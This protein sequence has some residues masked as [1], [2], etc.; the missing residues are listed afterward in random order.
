MAYCKLSDVV[1][2]FPQQSIQDLT[3][4]DLTGHVVDSVL[5]SAAD[6]ASEV[7]DSYVRGRY[8]TP[9]AAPVPSLILQIAVDLTVYNLYRRRFDQAM[10]EDIAKRREEALKMLREIQGGAVRLFNDPALPP[11]IVLGSKTEADREFSSDTLTR[12]I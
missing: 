3:D 1:Q 2:R 6:D 4:D 7:I 5:D 9:F 10:P 8:A 11:T 12:M